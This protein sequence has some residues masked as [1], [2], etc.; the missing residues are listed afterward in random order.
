M[1]LLKN[2]ELFLKTKMSDKYGRLLSMKKE[3]CN[4][5]NHSFGIYGSRI[6]YF[7]GFKPLYIFSC[8]N[9]TG[10]F[11]SHIYSRKN[12]VSALL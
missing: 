3:I 2:S 5:H 1:S 7:Y 6:H 9:I 10:I 8:H 12:T 4:K 11:Y